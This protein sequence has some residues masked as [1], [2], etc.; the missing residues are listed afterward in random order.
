[1]V[2]VMAFR[3]SSTRSIG[4]TRSKIER[5]TASLSA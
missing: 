1:M 5:P 2:A 4:T 3:L